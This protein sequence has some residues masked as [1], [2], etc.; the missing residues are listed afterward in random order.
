[1]YLELYFCWRVLKTFKTFFFCKK[2][3]ECWQN[4]LEKNHKQWTWLFSARICTKV[5][6]VREFSKL[7]EF[8]LFW[9][10]RLITW[11]KTFWNFQKQLFS[12][13]FFS[14]TSRTLLLVM[15]FEDVRKFCFFGK[16]DVFFSKNTW[17]F[18]KT[19]NTDIF[20]QNAFQKLLLLMQ[21]PNVQNLS[22]FEKQWRFLRKNP[23]K[24]SGALFG[25]F[26]RDCVSDFHIASE[27]SK[28]SNIWFVWRN[29]YFLLKDPFFSLESVNVAFL[30]QLAFQKI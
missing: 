27:F 13:V 2:K 11:K 3:I 19:L 23:W 8:G 25:V 10:N 22:F 30:S 20:L 12:Q 26:H 21:S 18:S 9:K 17:K 1:M 5:F 14:N 29:R 24:T 6:T 28:Q 7:S 16:R 4:I 15:C